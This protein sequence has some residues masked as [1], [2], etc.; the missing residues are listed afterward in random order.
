MLGMWS[1]TEK[2]KLFRQ[3]VL[4]VLEK[5]TGQQTQA[6]LPPA[7]ALPAPGTITVDQ[8][9]YI[10]LLKDKIRLLEDLNVVRIRRNFTDSEKEKIRELVASGKNMGEIG[11]AIGRSKSGVRS[12]LKREGISYEC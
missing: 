9:E 10:D 7:S 5:A 8:G 1:Q 12:Y 3:W 2:A 6:Q 11:R 4:D